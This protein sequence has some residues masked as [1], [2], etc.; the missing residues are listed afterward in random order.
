MSCDLP[1]AKTRASATTQPA[2]ASGRRITCCW[3][4]IR[5]RLNPSPPLRG[6][7]RCLLGRPADDKSA[8]SS[9]SVEEMNTRTCYRS[10]AATKITYVKRKPAKLSQPSAARPPS[11]QLIFLTGPQVVGKRGN[12]YPTPGTAGADSAATGG[13]S[14]TRRHR[15]AG[16]ER[17]GQPS[18][19]RLS[20]Y[21]AA[22]TRARLIGSAACS[23]PNHRSHL[24]WPTSSGQ[25][26]AAATSMG[27]IINARS[28]ARTYLPINHVRMLPLGS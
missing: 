19:G 1:S 12:A 18:T 3:P 23:V 15:S 9:S 24:T 20:G 14:V 28:L 22:A 16:S 4:T 27:H 10:R 17:H 7:T 8:A 5:L 2:H 11:H 26:Q 21:R 25:P 6:R 13:S